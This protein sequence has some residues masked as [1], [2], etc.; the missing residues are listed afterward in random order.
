VVKKI[1]G[2]TATI[3]FVLLAWAPRAEASAITV[4]GSTAGCFGLGCTNFGPN[5][6]DPTYELTFNGMGFTTDTDLAGNGSVTVGTFDRGNVNILNPPPPGLNF[7]LQVTFTIPLGVNGSPTSF[8]AFI[9]GQAASP[10]SIDFD[11]TWQ[12]FTYGPPSNLLGS[13]GFD[14][15]VLDTLPIENNSTGWLVT[16]EIRN[17]TF[18]PAVIINPNATVPEPGTLVLLATGLTALG[19]RLRKSLRKS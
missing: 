14:F 16:G 5:P 12:S 8:T 11:N 7:V 19:L 13:G 4:T 1:I 10:F 17:A 2:A 15:R 18:T 3:A 6:V 9:T